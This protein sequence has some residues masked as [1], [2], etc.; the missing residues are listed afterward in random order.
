MNPTVLITPYSYPS[1][2]P[3]PRTPGPPNRGEVRPDA[4]KRAKARAKRKARR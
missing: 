4:K 1:T 3:S 2:T